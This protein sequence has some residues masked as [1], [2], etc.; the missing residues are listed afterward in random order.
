[1]NNTC[2]YTVASGLYQWY[3][4]LF[5][6]CIEREYPEYDIK[7]IIQGICEL[8]QELMRHC[9]IDGN[10]NDKYGNNVYTTACIR[11]LEGEQ[12][13]RGYNNVLITDADVMIMRESPTLDLQHIRS[14]TDNG[15]GCYDNYISTAGKVSGVN[16]I[17]PQW[18][19]LTRAA[20]VK[21]ADQIAKANKV[22]WDYDENMLYGIIKDSGLQMNTKT[23]NMWNIHGLH[24]GKWRKTL[25][26]CVQPQADAMQTNY[27]EK[28]K[29]DKQFNELVAMVSAANPEIGNIYKN[30]KILL[31]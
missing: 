7:V 12:H 11:H 10:I 24:F 31:N 19:D 15:L 8:P 23:K 22:A 21:Y 29:S 25:S 2:I 3:I 9:V 30:I 14:M 5:V 28:L 17:R 4:P 20:R 6:N 26:W 16:F 1:M 13:L 27:I 18:W